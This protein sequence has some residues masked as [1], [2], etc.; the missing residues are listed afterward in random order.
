MSVENGEIKEIDQSKP[1]RIETELEKKENSVP[2]SGE[3]L[4]IYQN[5]KRQITSTI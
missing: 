1:K 2:N 4:E 3:V 5:L